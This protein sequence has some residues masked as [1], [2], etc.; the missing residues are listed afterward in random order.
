[1]YDIQI[2]NPRMECADPLLP[3]D[4]FGMLMYMV[5]NQGEN[6]H[7]KVIDL[8]YKLI[9]FGLRNLDFSQV[10]YFAL[11]FASQMLVLEYYN[12]YKMLEKMIIFLLYKFLVYYVANSLDLDFDMLFHQQTIVIPKSGSLCLIRLIVR[13]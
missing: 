13:I 10:S 4:I 9:F 6:F 3:S 5:N 8:I 11:V 2:S 1:M 12:E 7:Y